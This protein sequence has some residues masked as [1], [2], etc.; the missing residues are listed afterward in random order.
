M[1]YPENFVVRLIICIV[2]M[3]ALWIL[4][5]YLGAV[6]IR[7]EVFTLNATHF[8]VPVIV[9]AIEAFTWKPKDK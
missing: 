2:G 6:F 3:S 7:H 8:I 9:G 1:P 4:G 5:S